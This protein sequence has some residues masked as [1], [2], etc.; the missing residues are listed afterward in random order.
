MTTT[1][2]TA[3][4][5]HLTINGVGKVHIQFREW[6]L[7]HAGGPGGGGWWTVGECEWDGWIIVG[8]RKRDKSWLYIRGTAVRAIDRHW[9][10]R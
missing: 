9:D 7:P 10:Y 8:T 5:G 3:K 6:V 4:L 2:A 1:T